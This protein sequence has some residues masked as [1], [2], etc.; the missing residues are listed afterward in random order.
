MLMVVLVL[1]QLA[2]GRCFDAIRRELVV[3]WPFD[4]IKLVCPLIVAIKLL[5]M[6]VF[7]VCRRTHTKQHNSHDTWPNN[8]PGDKSVKQLKMY[9]ILFASN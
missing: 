4:Q 5:S 2:V 9:S 7:F 6:T 3:I 8:A 1:M